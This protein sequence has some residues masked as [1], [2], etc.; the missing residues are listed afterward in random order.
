[1]ADLELCCCFFFLMI[2]R[3]PRSTLFPYTTLFRSVHE[4]FYIATTGRPG[5]VLVDITKDVLQ[6][7][8]HYLP[9]TSI[10][11]PGYKVFTERHTGQI[12]RAVQLIQESAPPLV[13]SG[14]GIVAANASAELREFVTLTDAPV[15]TTLMGLGSLP[16]NHPNFISTQ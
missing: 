10:H 1:M 4:A 14:G 7:Q 15:V 6:G 12:R 16:S 5:P 8:G 13:F 9:V 3:P 11:L 2:R